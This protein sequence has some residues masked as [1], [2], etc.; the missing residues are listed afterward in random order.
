ML[1]LHLLTDSKAHNARNQRSIIIKPEIV[2][3]S[4]P[5]R[6]TEQDKKKWL[7]MLLQGEIGFNFFLNEERD[8]DESTP[9]G[10]VAFK[11]SR[12]GLK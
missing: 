3:G 2:Q 10:I 11:V 7:G 5:R 9:P 1:N 12:N 6:K 8:L 4:V